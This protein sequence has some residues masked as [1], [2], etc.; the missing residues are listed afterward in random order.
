MLIS[1]WDSFPQFSTV[2]LCVVPTVLFVVRRHA[3]ADFHTLRYEV[4]VRRSSTQYDLLSRQHS[5]SI[6]WT[7][8]VVTIVVYTD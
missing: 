3:D 5:V 1:A 8:L 7:I 4:Y 2:V 6:G